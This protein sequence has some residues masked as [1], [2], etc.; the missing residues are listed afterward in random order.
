MQKLNFCELNEILSVNILALYF[1][2]AW[3]IE[4]CKK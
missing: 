4:I 1:R 3:I 2:N